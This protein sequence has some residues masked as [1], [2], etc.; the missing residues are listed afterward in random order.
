MDNSD[1]MRKETMQ[2]IDDNVK[3]PNK[4]QDQGSKAPSRYHP[5][6]YFVTRLDTVRYRGQ[7]ST[8]PMMGKVTIGNCFYLMNNF[9]L[10]SYYQYFS[11]I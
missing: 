2:D 11:Q 10:L 4:K 6:N 5:N 9:R 3:K 8:V 7:N 1:D